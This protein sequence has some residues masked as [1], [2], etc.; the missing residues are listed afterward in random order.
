MVQVWE[1]AHAILGTTRQQIPYS[2]IGV[3]V[4]EAVNR[5]LEAI[6]AG[7]ARFEQ[8][9]DDGF[10]PPELASQPD[11]EIDED[12]KLIQD[13]AMQAEADESAAD[14]KMGYSKLQRRILQ[15]TDYYEAMSAIAS[16]SPTP[17]PQG[18]NEA[19]TTKFRGTI[20]QRAMLRNGTQVYKMAARFRDPI[21]GQPVRRYITETEW[22]VAMRKQLGLGM[23][24][25]H[26][27]DETSRG[28]GRC[29]C[30]TGNVERTVDQHWAAAGCR[31]GA[32]YRNTRHMR[33]QAAFYRLQRHARAGKAQSYDV[34]DY[35]QSPTKRRLQNPRN[36]ENSAMDTVIQDDALGQ[37][38][39]VDFTVFDSVGKT[40][41]GKGKD[42]TEV[43]KLAHRSKTI[44][45]ADSYA[46][47]ADRKNALLL[48]FAV[49]THG[50]FHPMDTGYHPTPRPILGHPTGHQFKSTDPG[51]LFKKLFDSGG[52]PARG[53]TKLS[54]EEG[55]IIALAKKAS[56]ARGGGIG[57]FDATLQTNS[58]AGLLAAHTYRDIAHQ[59]I[60]YS[61]RAT[62]Q[63]ID[64][65]RHA[66]DRA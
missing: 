26:G 6:E 53:G 11:A 1:D 35:T 45:K 24:G 60:V 8:H 66:F 48:T 27:R 18:W 64:C 36:N 5:S 30:G 7:R 21:S 25:V 2:P 23:A 50:N 40:L 49:D 37:T 20:Q 9:T 44:L 63:A 34:T 46:D 51:R 3:A 19:R 32:G 58:A 62:L 41:Q 14:I 38:I 42:A 52:A 55:L 28:E 4:S 17:L 29:A 13:K 12:L 31:Y 22:L 15:T 16:P 43:L 47:I 33:V 10:L 39:W 61:A 56:D 65:D 59:S 57:A 54:K